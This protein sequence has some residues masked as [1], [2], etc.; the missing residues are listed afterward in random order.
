FRDLRFMDETIYLRSGTLNI[1]NGIVGLT[2]SCD[3]SHYMPWNEFLDKRVEFW[4]GTS[5]PGAG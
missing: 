2:F 3:G 5:T 1:F 4:L